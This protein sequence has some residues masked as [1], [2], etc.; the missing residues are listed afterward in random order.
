MIERLGKVAQVFAHQGDVGGSDG[1]VGAHRAHGDTQQERPVGQDLRG[2]SAPAGTRPCWNRNH[3][4]TV[5]V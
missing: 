2:Q 4:A 1:H 5:Q 3:A